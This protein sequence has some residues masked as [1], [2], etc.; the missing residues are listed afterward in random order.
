MSYNTTTQSVPISRELSV[1]NVSP[2]TVCTVLSLQFQYEYSKTPKPNAYNHS[3]SLYERYILRNQFKFH[4]F[5]Y[6]LLGL[7]KY[8]CRGSKTIW[9]P[10]L[11]FLVVKVQYSTVCTY[12]SFFFGSSMYRRG[13]IL[14]CTSKTS[15]SRSSKAASMGEDTRSEQTI[16]K[17]DD[18]GYVS[19]TSACTDR[20][21]QCLRYF[22]FRCHLVSSEELRATL[23]TLARTV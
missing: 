20:L 12:C 9:Q 21:F 3:L 17:Y 22:F 23:K 13:S 8:C 1:V 2:S 19:M 11:V 5:H 4:V 15:F 16:Y 7:K 18:N 14:C 6:C 10:L